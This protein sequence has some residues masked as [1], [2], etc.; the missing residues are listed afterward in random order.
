MPGGLQN[1][2]FR[3]R[4]SETLALYSTHFSSSQNVSCQSR[5]GLTAKI[6]VTE[7]VNLQHLRRQP[8]RRCCPVKTTCGDTATSQTIEE[9]ETHIEM[10]IFPL[11]LCDFLNVC[12]LQHISPNQW[13]KEETRDLYTHSHTHT[14][15]HTHKHTLHTP[16]AISFP[17]TLL[18]PS[19]SLTVNCINI[20]LWA[21]LGFR[22]WP[23]LTSD[24]RLERDKLREE[25]IY[26]L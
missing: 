22:H 23:A 8:Q 3:F 7:E 1:A 16:L 12:H 25:R 6:S 13:Q 5:C 21:L 9:K 18:V 10:S 26:I 17:A 19:H 24:T 4:N 11:M 2:G 15:T 14:L 20:L